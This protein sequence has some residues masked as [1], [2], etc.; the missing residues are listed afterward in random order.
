MVVNESIGSVNIREER[1]LG[2]ESSQTS[3]LVCAYF[4]NKTF[5][6]VL[7]QLEHNL[8]HSAALELFRALFLSIGG[9]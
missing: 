6:F 3:L 8:C 4:L 1:I 9:D 5:Q 7:V 2:K